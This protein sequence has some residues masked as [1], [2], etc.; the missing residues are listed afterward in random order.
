MMPWQFFGGHCEIIIVFRLLFVLKLDIFIFL[1]IK[2][3][4]CGEKYFWMINSNLYKKQYTNVNLT[5]N[6]MVWG[7][8]MLFTCVPFEIMVVMTTRNGIYLILQFQNLTYTCWRKVSKLQ[9]EFSYHSRDI[10]R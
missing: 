10:N 4:F 8:L 9:S 2:L 6:V 7:I 5:S 1:H 3:K